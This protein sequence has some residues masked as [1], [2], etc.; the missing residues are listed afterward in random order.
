MPLTRPQ[1]G[2]LGNSQ[3]TSQGVA[4]NVGV[5]IIENTAII[6]SN[7]SISTGT[8]AHSVGP[9]TIQSGVTVTIPTGAVWK[10]T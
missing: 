9:V 5:P 3:I 8:N 10:I 1:A 7:Y 4:L 6:A 2:I